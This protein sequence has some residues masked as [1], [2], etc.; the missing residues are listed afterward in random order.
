[1]RSSQTPATPELTISLDQVC[2]VI[3]KLR[4]FEVKDVATVADPGSNASDDG[5]ADVL[6]DRPGD[7]T[8]Q[9]LRRFISAMDID[10]QA[11]L[12]AL[13]WL[14][15]G[16]YDLNETK[17]SNAIKGVG[18]A[19]VSLIF[20]ALA[21]WMFGSEIEEQLD[22][23]Y[24]TLCDP[25]LNAD[26]ALELAFLVAE[27]LKKELAASKEFRDPIVTEIAPFKAFFSAEDYHQGYFRGNPTQGYCQAVVGPKVAKFRKKFADKLK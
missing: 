20:N 22:H 4:Q 13:A 26:Q 9:E 11:D 6:E 17:L 19:W 3:T 8:Q 18:G 23:R 21:I 25:R 15:R 24:E 2:F 27:Q 1:M 10:R 14:G 5:M 16:D 12:V 7:A